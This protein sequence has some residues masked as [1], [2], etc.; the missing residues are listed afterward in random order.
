M[1][2]EILDGFMLI[3]MFSGAI[4]IQ[5]CIV[6]E[7]SEKDAGDEAQPPPKSKSSKKDKVNTQDIS[8]SFCFKISNKV[9]YKTVVKGGL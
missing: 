7:W 1:C 3:F 8:D 2:V 4:Y 6:D 5:E 9:S